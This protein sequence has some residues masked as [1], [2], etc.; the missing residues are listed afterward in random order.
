[1]TPHMSDQGDHEPTPPAGAQPQDRV[2]SVADSAIFVSAWESHVRGEPSPTGRRRSIRLIREVAQTALV[3]LILFAGTRTV[4]QGRQVRGPS[5][6]P[7]YHTGQRVFVTRYVFGEPRR[8]DVIVFDP[9]VPS[10]DDLIKRVIGVPGDRVVVK[11]GTVSVNGERLDESYLAGIK[12]SCFGRYC[13]VTLG[14]GQYFVMGDNRTNS[15]DSRL[16]GPVQSGSIV[17]KAWLLYYP[18]SDFGLAP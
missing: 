4:V 9:P 15:S 18:F 2:R 8:G 13:D 11:E 12:T 7:T 6:Q 3:A 5:M 14:A 10:E 17:G 16:W 1:M